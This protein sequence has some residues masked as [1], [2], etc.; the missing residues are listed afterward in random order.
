MISKGVK[1]NQNINEGCSLRRTRKDES[2]YA[3]PER[4]CLRTHGWKAD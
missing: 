4:T 2:N 3:V 1:F